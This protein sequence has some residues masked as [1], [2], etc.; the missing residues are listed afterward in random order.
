VQYGFIASLMSST[1]NISNFYL[2]DEMFGIATF[3]VTSIYKTQ[4]IMQRK[5][6]VFAEENLRTI[7]F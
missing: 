1:A 4:N 6:F 3:K 2:S 5:Y 7:T